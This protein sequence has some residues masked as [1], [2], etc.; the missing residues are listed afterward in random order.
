MMAATEKSLPESDPSSSS[1]SPA[2]RSIV[3]EAPFT[4]GAAVASSPSPSVSASSESISS[5]SSSAVYESWYDSSRV[6]RLLPLMSPDRQTLVTVQRQ[7]T[8]FE[9]FFFRATL[10]LQVVLAVQV[11]RLARLDG[12][13]P[14][15]D[16]VRSRHLL[17][18]FVRCR[19]QEGD[20]EIFVR[21]RMWA[22]ASSRV[23][24]SS[25]CVLDVWTW[26]ASGLAW[27]EVL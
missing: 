7:E 3:L 13:R 15:C 25:W 19:R 22:G 23:Q 9:M 4:L 12:A 18:G 11:D 26:I 24:R 20:W 1:S 27:S 5:S 6:D 16:G 21:R 2:T 8:R 10:T 14:E 17:R